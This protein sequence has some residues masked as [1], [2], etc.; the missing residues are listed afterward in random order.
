M[1]KGISIHIGLDF[2]DEQHYGATHTLPFCTNDA[3][4]ME[5]IASQIGYESYVLLNENATSHRFFYFLSEASASLE[6]DDILFISFS[7]HGSL[8]KDINGDEEDGSDETLVFFD[9]MVVD[10][11]L[12]QRWN[13]FK[14]GVRI[15]FISDSCHSGTITKE[16]YK[17]LW[18]DLFHQQQKRDEDKGMNKVYLRNKDMYDS[19]LIDI[20]AHPKTPVMCSVL[21]LSACQEDQ[22]AAAT[23]SEG[24]VLSPF[25]EILLDSWA[26]GRF[27]GNYKDFYSIIRKEIRRLNLRQR[28]N[29]NIVGMKHPY[30]E[31]QIP[32]SI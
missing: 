12:Y 24:S 2:V 5:A 6:M 28:P 14:K 21:L 9:R 27:E 13:K 25:T 19:Q 11:E 30:F 3:K 29:Y 26:D 15:L 16:L 22:V 23:G 20:P 8:V 18:G 17:S 31:Q 4:A 1:A 7:G 10:D 32:F